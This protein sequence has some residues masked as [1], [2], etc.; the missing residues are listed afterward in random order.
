MNVYKICAIEYYDKYQCHISPYYNNLNVMAK[1]NFHSPVLLQSS[2][3]HDLHV[4]IAFLFYHIIF[5]LFL[6]RI[7]IYSLTYCLPSLW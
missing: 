5:L 7:K 4:L 2:G 3:S 6:I 1:L